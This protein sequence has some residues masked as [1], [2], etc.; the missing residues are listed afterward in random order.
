[1]NISGKNKDSDLELLKMIISITASL[2]D[3]IVVVD[4]SGLVIFANKDLFGQKKEEVIRKN[5][6]DFVLAERKSVMTNAIETIFDSGA[7]VIIDQ[8]DIGLFNDFVGDLC[9]KPLMEDKQVKW[10]MLILRNTSRSLAEHQALV[11]QSSLQLL[12]ER[13]KAEQE[14]I[15]YLNADLI[16][17][18]QM[19]Y[20][21]KLKLE[22][23]ISDL[24]EAQ[25]QLIHAEKMASLGVMTAG[26]AHEIN[27]PLNFI[28]GGYEGLRMY[29]NDPDQND[30]EVVEM[31]L[32]NIR[33]GIE[34]TTTIV[35]GLGQFSRNN[36]SFEEVCDLKKII[37][38][39]L[40]I[41]KSQYKDRIIIDQKHLEELFVNGNVG[42]LHQ[43]FL[44]LLVNSIHAIED[45]GHIFIAAYR[46]VENVV[47]EISDTGSG[48]REEDLVKLSEPF[49]TTKEPGKGTGLGLTI[50][51][52]I[53]REHRGTLEFQSELGKGTKAIVTIPDS[54]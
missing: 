52:S 17:T 22:K 45:E 5:I 8:D 2:D 3:H 33:I 42:K 12:N 54:I 23:T 31:L 41:L 21:D 38:N 1:M 37:N 39:C 46:H 34:R 26:V 14:K 10:A 29:C 30:K 24:V 6:C 20:N 36:D 4:R 49:F 47:I 13:L 16:A 18:N 7:D 40:I 9:I 11:E 25:S 53:V 19:I 27:N 32:E 15:Q 51:Y 28:L 35:K 43:V 44:N 48:I 50:C